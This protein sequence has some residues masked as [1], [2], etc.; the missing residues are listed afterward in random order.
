MF[1]EAEEVYLLI[2]FIP[3]ASN[4]FEAA[5]AVSKTMGTY[6]NYTL[7]D[8]YKLAVHEKFFC[9]H[10]FGISSSFATYLFLLFLV[11]SC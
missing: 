3:I 9:V 11:S 1:A 2:L 6:R 5:C 10:F 4:A 8:G 7:L